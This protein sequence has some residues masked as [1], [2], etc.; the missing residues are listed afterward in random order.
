MIQIIAQ[1]PDL[2]TADCFA[3]ENISWGFF[4]VTRKEALT[5][6]LNDLLS[7]E[8]EL[9]FFQLC[10]LGYSGLLGPSVS[11]CIVMNGVRFKM[12]SHEQSQ[13]LYLG[14]IRQ[15]HLANE[16]PVETSLMGP[17][18]C[19]LSFP[20]PAP[21]ERILDMSDQDLLSCCH[22]LCMTVFLGVLSF[23]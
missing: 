17:A 4:A 22:G 16:Q 12:Y 14:K 13:G 15:S 20:W 8:P 2:L 6:R 5:N 3:I 7:W 1:I 18:C 19:G 21:W 11:R 23:H 9:S 10:Q